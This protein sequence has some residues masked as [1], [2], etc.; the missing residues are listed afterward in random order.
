MKEDF[1][2]DVQVYFTYS[3]YGLGHQSEG[4]A[5]YR[6]WAGGPEV[7][8]QDFD[9]S[10]YDVTKSGIDES[11]P[12]ERQVISIDRAHIFVSKIF[13]ISFSQ[14]PTSTPAMDG[15]AYG[16]TISRSGFSQTFGWY[17]AGGWEPL[18]TAA[19]LM[20]E[21]LKEVFPQRFK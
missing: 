8:L 12:F 6:D 18:D 19:N 2:S 14:M 3:V 1:P 7:R 11:H 10:R 20:R 21:L 15:V 17:D 4:R 13:A 16:L 9:L 5:H